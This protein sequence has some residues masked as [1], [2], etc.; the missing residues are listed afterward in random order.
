MN[1]KQ[2]ILGAILLLL[3]GTI[4]LYLGMNLL[5]TEKELIGMA[6]LTLQGTIAIFLGIYILFNLKKEDEIE[7][8]IYEQTKGGKKR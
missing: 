8:P 2:G 1:N 3:L 5:L 6:I 4:F 7:L